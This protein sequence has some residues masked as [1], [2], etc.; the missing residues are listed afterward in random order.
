MIRGFFQTRRSI[1][2]LPPVFDA[3]IQMWGFDSND[4]LPN[5]ISKK[6]LI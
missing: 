2:S 1:P 6:A 3:K 4:E 5:L